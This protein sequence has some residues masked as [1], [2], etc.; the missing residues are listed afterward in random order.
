MASAGAIRQL[1][2]QADVQHPRKA[3]IATQMSFLT[4]ALRP[5]QKHRIKDPSGLQW[6][7]FLGFASK[8]TCGAEQVSRQRHAGATSCPRGALRR[9]QGQRLS[10]R[11]RQTSTLLKMRYQQQHDCEEQGQDS[12]D[13]DQD[14]ALDSAE[15]PPGLLQKWELNLLQRSDYTQEA[16]RILSAE[17]LC[18]IFEQ[19][20]GASVE[21]AQAKLNDMLNVC[22][23][24]QFGK[25]D[26]WWGQIEEN[27]ATDVTLLLTPWSESMGMLLILPLRH[28]RRRGISV[29]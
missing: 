26:H 27:K 4:E 24:M 20:A 21:M 7:P 16:L 11:I 9:A 15:P 13:Q 14:A 17:E 18:E 25:K 2:G 3:W 12:Q 22:K 1:A 5:R 23:D 28:S 10:W 6:R 29:F 19:K 8:G